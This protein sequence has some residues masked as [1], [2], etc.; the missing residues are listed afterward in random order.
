MD[1]VLA[2]WSF[3]EQFLCP[4]PW[5]SH[6]RCRGEDLVCLLVSNNLRE[7]LTF[8]AAGEVVTEIIAIRAGPLGE[9]GGK[10][11]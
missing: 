4:E 3:M 6:G 5:A 9:E 1:A 7:G 11:R 8:T 2:V 10:H